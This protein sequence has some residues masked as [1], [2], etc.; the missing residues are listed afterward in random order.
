MTGTKPPGRVAG[1]VQQFRLFIDRGAVPL[2]FEQQA[3]A[4]DGD[5][6]VVVGVFGNDNDVGS[7]G[8]REVELI[9][10]R[11]HDAPI[12]ELGYGESEDGATWT[13]LIGAEAMPCQT[14]M[15]KIFQQELLKIF[16]EDV[17]WRPWNR[18]NQ[19]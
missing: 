8:R 10:S 18:V 2:Q 14:T 17:V 15:G 1:Y 4:G 19:E 6:P 12:E 5:I 11:L 3:P 7:G 13:M 16:L 9:R